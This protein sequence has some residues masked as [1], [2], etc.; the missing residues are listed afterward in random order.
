MQ[1]KVLIGSKAVEH[2]KGDIL[3]RVAKDTDYL[4]LTPVT[5][6]AFDRV[7]SIDGNGILD[8]YSFESAIATIDEVYTLKV[9]HSPWVISSLAEWYKHLHDISVL[10]NEGATVVEELY[11]VAYKEWE[12]RKGAK[13]VNLEQDKEEFFKNTVKR[14]YDHDSVHAAV[15]LGVNPAFELI[16]PPGSEVKP[17][18]M[19]FEKLSEEEKARLV[20]EEVMV[21]ALEREVVPRAMAGGFIDKTFLFEAYS[22]HLRLL[23]TQ[24]SKGWFPRWI[25]E[26]FF[27]V[28]TP[29]LDYWKLFQDS[30]KK[31][32][33]WR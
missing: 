16:L 4:S 29:P 14:Y 22:K 7:D 31:I 20:F 30:D 32:P 6:P 19:L 17:S 24:Y 33:L 28:S 8:K 2:H 25:I 23:V 15:A 10:K 12:R 3:G 9:S 11:T 5:C 26:N 13:Q 21:L 1:E 27:L 18:K